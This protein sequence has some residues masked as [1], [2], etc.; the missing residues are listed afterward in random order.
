VVKNEEVLD[1]CF[2]APQEGDVSRP[3]FSAACTADTYASSSAAGL[4]G[5][6]RVATA[7]RSIVAARSTNATP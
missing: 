2:D 7:E 1:L 5:G 3:G 6:N 4:V